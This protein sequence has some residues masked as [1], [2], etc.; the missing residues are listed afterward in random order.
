MA[1]SGTSHSPAQAKMIHDQVLRGEHSAE[2]YAYIVAGVILVFA[3]IHWA[4]RLARRWHLQ[5]TK[6]GRSLLLVTRPMTRILYGR[7]FYG[8]D[9][10]PERVVLLV[11]Y[12]GINIGLAFWQIDF[13]HYTTFANRLGW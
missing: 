13:K 11:A 6:P 2:Y 9:V 3:H 4:R 8:I 7:R 12:F 1:P 5:A 10:I